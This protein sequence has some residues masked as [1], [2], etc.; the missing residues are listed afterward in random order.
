[1]EIND[2]EYMM[3][4]PEVTYPC[5]WSY[6]VITTDKDYIA[7]T[8]PELLESHDYKFA[9]SNQSRTGKYTSFSITL[10][11]SSEE[12]RNKIFNILRCLPSV[13]MVL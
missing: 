1:M 11:V 2:K 3:E 7:K 12:E 13:K 8:I 5:E 4:K 9:E 6:K 10:R